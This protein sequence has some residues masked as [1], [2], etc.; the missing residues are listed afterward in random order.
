LPEEIEMSPEVRELVD[1]RWSEYGIPLGR[2]AR[3]G[4]TRHI[5]RPSRRL[6][7]R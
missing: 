2:A 7:R 6:L 4:E 3:N 5:P 1:R